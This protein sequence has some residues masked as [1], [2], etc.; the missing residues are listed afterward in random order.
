MDGTTLL[1]VSIGLNVLLSLWLAWRIRRHRIC[2]S[3][4]TRVR[5]ER[6]DFKRRM[7]GAEARARGVGGMG[8]EPSI[9]RIS[10]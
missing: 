5:L 3:T 4:L 9:E 6:D 8:P 10:G 7:L 2:R 1:I